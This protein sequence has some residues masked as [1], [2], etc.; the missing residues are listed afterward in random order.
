MA[1][2]SFEPI[3]VWIKNGVNQYA[4]LLGLQYIFFTSSW[5]H[6]ICISFK[7]HFKYVL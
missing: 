2:Q 6:K 4:T 1:E 5:F 3:L 7:I